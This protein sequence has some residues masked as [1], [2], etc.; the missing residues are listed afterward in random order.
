MAVNEWR[1]QS[2]MAIDKSCPHF[3][4]QLVV[5]IESVFY[6]CP[7]VQHGWRYA[8]NIIWQLFANKRNLGPHNSF[9]MVQCLFDEPLCKILKMF[10][11]IWFFLRSG[12]P[13][14]IWRQ[15]NNLVINNMQWHVEKTRKVIWDALQ[16]YGWIEW[17]QTLK[18]L[19]EALD[20]AYQD[21]LKDFDTTWRVK[22]LI[23]IHSNLVVTWMDRP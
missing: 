5:S 14:I 12:L 13:W 16:D 1:G 8:S 3:G 4:P 17:K 9:S 6:N 19:E 10:N 7:L 18:D 11:C 22:K 20:V 21:V 15:R 2:W 23:V